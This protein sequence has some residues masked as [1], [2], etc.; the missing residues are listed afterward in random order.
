M[1]RNNGHDND[2]DE[3]DDEDN[4]DDDNENGR[5]KFRDNDHDNDHE[6]DD[7]VELILLD[8]GVSY[9]LMKSPCISCTPLQ[10]AQALI[11]RPLTFQQLG[12]H[13]GMIFPHAL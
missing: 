1:H 8:I 2:N 7:D 12:V 6:N 4:D 10:F 5:G 9:F 11:H 13:P 3:S